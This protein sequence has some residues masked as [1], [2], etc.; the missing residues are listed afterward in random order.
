MANY[1]HARIALDQALGTTLEANNVSLD[2]ALAGRISRP[3][4]L[5]SDLPGGERR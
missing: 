4:T 2:E 5:P 1:S 3:S